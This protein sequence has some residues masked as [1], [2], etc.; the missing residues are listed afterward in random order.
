MLLLYLSSSKKEHLRQELRR[1]SFIW[2]P[3]PRKHMGKSEMKKES[4]ES[5]QRVD[6]FIGFHRRHLRFSPTGDSLRWLCRMCFR[7]ALQR[8]KLIN[9]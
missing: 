5:I 2:V 1:G 6:I 7:L 3:G 4:E 8:M 9:G